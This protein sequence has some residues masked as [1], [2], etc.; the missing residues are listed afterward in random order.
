M[1]KLHPIV[2]AAL[3]MDFPIRRCSWPEGEYVFINTIGLI[4]GTSTMAEAEYEINSKI[5]TVSDWD[6]VPFL[7]KPWFDK[8]T[9][10]IRFE[11]FDFLLKSRP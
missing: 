10:K 2:W 4:S 7:S 6:I 5:E 11:V 3:H 8:K 1:A 9:Q